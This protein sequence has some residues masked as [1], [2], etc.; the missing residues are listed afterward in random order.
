[1]LDSSKSGVILLQK[2]GLDFSKVIQKCIPTIILFI[3][4]P[5]LYIRRSR[6][7]NHHNHLKILFISYKLLLIENIIWYKSILLPLQHYL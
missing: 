4:L 1:M 7:G 6:Q 3:A 2:L 5:A